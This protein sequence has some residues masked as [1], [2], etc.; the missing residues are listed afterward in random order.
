MTTAK[1]RVLVVEDEAILAMNIEK[2]L[3]KLGY[4]VA[5]STASGEEA[6]R[7]AA[8]QKPDLV[9]MDI[10]LG[11]HIDGVEAAEQIQSRLDIPVVYL[12]AFA[13][14]ET[15]R[16]AKITSPFGYLL[17]P[18]KASDLQVALELALY[19]HKIEQRLRASEA[20]YR[21]LFEGIPLGL[22]RTTPAGQLVD[23]NPALLQLLGNPPPS[24]VAQLNIGD[25]FPTPEHYRRYQALLQAEGGVQDFQTELRQPVSGATLAVEINARGF[26]GPDGQPLYHEGSITDITPRLQAEAEKAELQAQ[27]FQAQKMEALGRLTGG[28]AHDFN[29]L[30]TVINGFSELMQ[31]SLPADS[32]LQEMVGQILTTGQRAKNLVRQLL[33]FSSQRITEPAAPLDLN[34]LIT[35]LHKMIGRIIGEHIEMELELAADLGIIMADPAQI[36]QVIINLVVNARDA[37]P[38]GGKLSLRTANIEF[39][40]GPAQQNIGLLPGQYVMLMVRDD[41]VGIA[42][43]IKSHIFEPFFTT[44]TP[45]QGTGLGLAICYGIIK[46]HGGAIRVDTQPGYGATFTIYL[47]RATARDN[48]PQHRY[49]NYQDIPRGRETILV[50][51][52]DAAVRGLVANAL[53]RQGYKVLEAASG[54][55]ALELAQE[56]R[57][58]I[59]LLFT[60]MVMPKL[61]GK[62]LAERW[63]VLRPGTKFIFMSG[64]TDENLALH[65][66]GINFI[67]KPFS[68]AAMA[69]QVR[70]VLD[71]E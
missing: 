62:E 41:G 39:E 58:E 50:A 45:G 18:F 38:A 16:R 7:Q 29:N 54:Y 57:D 30:L 3:Q 31:Y 2:M 63:Q 67:Q 11:G 47:P 15:L 51:E 10:K 59:H 44:K 4:A 17:K 1:G 49:L 9:L 14:D 12:T 40:A 43:D 36:E 21:S 55:E 22:F 52:D 46:Q 64:Y 28:I 27:L 26:V 23:L 68:P 35:E 37:M 53:R 5:A 69:R 60:D 42:A 32:P 34:G 25:L 19:K 71:R 56:Y 13:D 6:V 8:H 70:V 65:H 20:H 66:D 48:L 24:R 61:G 33:V